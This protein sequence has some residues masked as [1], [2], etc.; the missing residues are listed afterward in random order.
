M[1]RISYGVFIFLLSVCH[2]QSN[3]GDIYFLDMGVAIE[4]KN[5][6]GKTA[7]LIKPNLNIN[8]FNDNEK[9]KMLLKISSLENDLMEMT[10]NFAKHQI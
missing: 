10:M 3:N 5:D 1:Y 2:S 8:N 7:K 6:R 4:P 9:K